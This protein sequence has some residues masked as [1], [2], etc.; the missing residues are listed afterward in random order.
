MGPLTAVH[1]AATAN[2]GHRVDPDGKSILL[3]S[4][5]EDVSCGAQLRKLAVQEQPGLAS[6]RVR[7]PQHTGKRALAEEQEPLDDAGFA[8]PVEPREHRCSGQLDSL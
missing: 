4:F 7:R 6:T 8:H 2:A 3:C 1:L 5:I